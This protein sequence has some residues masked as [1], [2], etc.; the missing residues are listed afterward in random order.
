MCTSVPSRIGIGRI[1]RIGIQ[2]TD[3]LFGKIIA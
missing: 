2:Y 1:Q 3:Q